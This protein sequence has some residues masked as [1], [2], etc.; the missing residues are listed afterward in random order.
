MKAKKSA[1][2]HSEDRLIVGGLAGV[3]IAGV[4]T[5]LSLNS[6]TTELWLALGSYSVS[7]PLLSCYLLILTTEQSYDF[8]YYPRY[9]NVI[10][11]CG[12]FLCYFGIFMLFCHFSY[13]LGVLF[14]A[15][16][17]MAAIYWSMFRTCMPCLED[18]DGN[19]E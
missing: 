12:M 16:S 5:I 9:R 1:Q 13:V 15:S 8:A 19:S 7:L 6:I 18:S 11:N 10:A 14:F 3:G 17:A 2:V 4:L